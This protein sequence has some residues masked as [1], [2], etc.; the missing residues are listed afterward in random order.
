MLLSLMMPILG[1]AKIDSSR[2][3]TTLS[4]TGF[5]SEVE[6]YTKGRKALPKEMFH[7]IK[8]LV[9]PDADILDI[10]CGNGRITLALRE[11][12]TSQ[13]TGFDID[14]K[15]I[16][17]AKKNANEKGFHIPF[18]QGDVK[19]LAQSFMKGRF[20]AI[21][22]SSSLHWFSTPEDFKAIRSVLNPQGF[23]IVISGGGGG[24]SN[25]IKNVIS[26]TIGRELKKDENDAEN[27]LKNNGFSIVEIKKFTVEHIYT[28]EEAVANVM[29]HSYYAELTQAEKEKVRPV[30]EQYVKGQLKD[31]VIRKTSNTK[32]IVAKPNS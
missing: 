14:D 23:L 16:N 13:V 22:A 24:S 18:F 9:K 29:S 8:N 20:D 17:E 5:G 25:E 27:N 10:G 1:F 31:G 11:H 7:W 21:T 3:E 19:E 26:E 6:N 30:I 32:C 28:F 15:M 4:G 2:K 12:V